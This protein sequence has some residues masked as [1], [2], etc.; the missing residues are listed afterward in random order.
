MSPFGRRRLRIAISGTLLAMSAIAVNS[1]PAQ[2]ATN[3]APN[4]PVTFGA[5]GTG[6]LVILPTTLTVGDCREIGAN[7]EPTHVASDLY[8]KLDPNTPNLYKVTWEPDLYT[9]GSTYI[10]NDVW[11]AWFVFK[12]STTDEGFQLH[13]D[14]PEMV[15]GSFYVVKMAA[16]VYMTADQ[17]HALRYVDFGG[18]C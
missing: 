16:Y 14:G 15:H 3:L 11:H 6:A 18:D 5:S 12:K 10:F 17:F 1:S 4:V 13:F 8:I 9:I 7:Q 2:A